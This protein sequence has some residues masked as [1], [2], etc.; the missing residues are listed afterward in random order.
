MFINNFTNNKKELENQIETCTNTTHK[1][2]LQTFTG[3]E[4]CLKNKEI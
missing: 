3:L 1:L 4:L 2:C